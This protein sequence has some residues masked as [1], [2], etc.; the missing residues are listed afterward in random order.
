M[1]AD[2]GLAKATA[3]KIVPD[4]VIGDFD[5]FSGE[6]PAGCRALRFPG[7]KD[8]TDTMLCLRHGIEKGFRE[9]VVAGGVGGRLD[10]TIANMQAMSFCIDQGG[11]I[12]ISDGKNRATMVRAALTLSRG[13]C[14]G[15]KSGREIPRYFSLFA[16]SER[17]SGVSV[18]GAKYNLR[19]A[20][21]DHSFP[22]GLSNEFAGE[23]VL[24]SVKSG[25][26]LVVLSED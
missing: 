3:E 14:G 6:I 11:S 10:H 4:I 5:S 20:I 26:L 22:L 2:G 13:D 24:I 18:E 1:C 23:E 9:F 25:K 7:E 21:L 16:Y 8:D 12:W 19:D 15:D 17:C